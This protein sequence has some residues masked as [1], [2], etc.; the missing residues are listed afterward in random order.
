M[1]HLV[2]SL[3]VLASLPTWEVAAI[4]IF[5]VLVPM[6]VG[7]DYFEGVPYQVSYSAQLGDAGLFVVVLIAADILHRS[8]AQIP[9]GE[10][11]T[12]TQEMHFI[13]WLFSFVICS[14]L[15]RVT[16][17]KRSGK[18]MDIY[19][20]VVI[21]PLFIYLAF[22][23]LPVIYSY[24]TWVEQ[25]ATACFALLWLALVFFDTKYK[26]MNQREWLKARGLRFKE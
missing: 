15:S 9:A 7:R 20:D 14:Q 3:Y 11:V 6:F 23:L 26:R 24:G 25:V 8:G 10:G 4:F 21:V 2:G 19:H 16:L 1:E 12:E 5:V 18:L 22:T 17:K 13:V